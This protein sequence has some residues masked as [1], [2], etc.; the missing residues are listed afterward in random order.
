MHKKRAFTLI[1]LL[2]VIAIIAL[3]MAILLPAL[4]AGKE[5]GA[6][7]ACL[8]NLRQLTLAWIMYADN[9]DDKIPGSDVGYER[10]PG[11]AN[12]NP[13]SAWW[14]DAPSLTI[15]PHGFAQLNTL[16]QWQEAERAI[17]DGRLWPYLKDLKPYKCP[18][19]RRDEAMTYNIVDSMNGY[20][21]WSG[22]P[23][24]IEFKLKVTN[25]MQIR[26]PGDRIVFFCESPPTRGSWGI[27]CSKEAW[28][29]PPP[30]RHGK[31][32]TFSFADG[33]S[34]FWKWRDK[35][36]IEYD[37]NRDHDKNQPGNEDLY[38]MQIA[39]WGQLCY[40]PSQ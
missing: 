22:V 13:R 23:N 3:L 5:Q 39:V 10:G 6:R 17:K 20:C 8:N 16:E 31:G 28:W 9:S 40:T 18:A 30:L 2:V 26:R 36:T 12:P 24:G 25:R 38:R 21:G 34:E 29:D 27:K 11:D 19:G 14:V 35:R 1:E 37:Y 32:A 33:H 7:A 15:C 4:Q